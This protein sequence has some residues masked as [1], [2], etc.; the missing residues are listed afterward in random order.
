MYFGRL[1]WWERIGITFSSAPQ[2]FIIESTEMIHRPVAAPGHRGTKFRPMSYNHGFIL[3]SLPKTITRISKT[4]QIWRYPV[5]FLLFSVLSWFIITHII[6]GDVG[7]WLPHSSVPA[8]ADYKR[9]SSQSRVHF[10]VLL[11]VFVPKGSLSRN[12]GSDTRKDGCDLSNDLLSGVCISWGK[13]LPTC[14]YERVWPFAKNVDAIGID[15]KPTFYF[16]NESHQCSNR[17]T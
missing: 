6:R 4:I 8:S 5:W 3:S 12:G 2:F 13:A 11:F 14:I 10:R 17:Y 16:D 1:R 7:V 9:G 15:T